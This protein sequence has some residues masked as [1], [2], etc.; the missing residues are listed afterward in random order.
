VLIGA[1]YL[2][3]ASS[4]ASTQNGGAPKTSPSISK[5]AKSE[6]DERPLS[7][8]ER[9]REAIRK[10]AVALEI[11]VTEMLSSAKTYGDALE[12]HKSS[13]E[14]NMPASNADNFRAEML[15]ELAAMQAANDKYR[16]KLDDADAHIAA[17]K[18]QLES[19]QEEA[20][21]DFL[22]KVPNRRALDTKFEEEAYRAKRY[23]Q[24]LSLAFVDIDDFKV[25]NDTH[26][27]SVG[28]R[29]LRG[30]A[31]KI[32]SS[33]RQSDFF[34]RYGGEE[35]AVLLPGTTVDVA[36]I[37]A[38]KLRSQ[39]ENSV[40]RLN[41]VELRVTVSIGIGELEA[42]QEDREQFISRVDAAM[43]KAKAAGRNRVEKAEPIT[44]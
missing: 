37:V 28:D 27:H 6:T 5:D 16:T 40:F 7:T 44:S 8:A 38:E 42:E 35:F 25:L 33:V 1:L 39:L 18:G 12:G 22:T 34:A 29:V 2:R 23:N 15:D 14:K 17:Q 24:P 43:Y 19:L 41:D 32:Q 3:P 30:I 13:I 10:L 26:G 11:T 31:M 36:A 20:F 9:A 21:I 4:T